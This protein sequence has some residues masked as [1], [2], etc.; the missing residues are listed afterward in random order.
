MVHVNSCIKEKTM[1]VAI[2]G[3]GIG[4]MTLGLSLHAAGFDDVDIYES[5]STVKELGV[6]INLQSHALRGLTELGFLDD[7]LGVGSPSAELVYYSKHGQ[8]IVSEPRGLDAGYRWPQILIHRGQLLG[9]L[10]RAV[11]DRL[12]PTRVHT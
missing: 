1:H 8:R 10:Y 2:V 5:A 11:L 12:G 9:I 3:G 4:G 7:L 6:S